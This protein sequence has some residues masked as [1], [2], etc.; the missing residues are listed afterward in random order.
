[1]SAIE[2]ATPAQKTRRMVVLLAALF[3]VAVPAI[4]YA[5]GFG[6]TQE[7]FAADGNSTL[8]VAGY[9][10]SI[11][12]AIYVGLLIYAGRQAL[13]QTGESA[14]INHMGWPSA[15]SMFGIG[16]WIIAAATNQKWAS[17]VI[18]FVSLLVLLLPLLADN[19]R[20]RATALTSRERWFLIWPL[21]A[22]AGWLT[23]ASPLNLLTTA[24]A[25]DV[26]PTALTP[27]AWALVAVVAV[28]VIGLGVT[29]GLRTLFYP[30]PIAWGLI[31][32]FV[33]EQVRNPVLGFSA[34]GAALLLVVGS[35][36][37]TFGLKRGISR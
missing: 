34:L 14:L 25:L 23:I 2:R 35:V 22:L 6:L 21:T 32:A 30:M 13:P 12:G 33:A 3:A 28:L 36:I 37:I 5:T 20:I 16:A 7:E 17:V 31:G 8:Q 15:L 11:W 27:T 19:R 4:Q 9:A 18:I 29:Y 24:T 26:L 1:M 10:F